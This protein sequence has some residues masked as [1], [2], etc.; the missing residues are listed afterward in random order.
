MNF[1][2][3]KCWSKLSLNLSSRGHSSLT[4]NENGSITVE[5]DEGE[6]TVASFQTFPQRSTGRRRSAS[7]E[8]AGY[9]AGEDGDA[10]TV[11]W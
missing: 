1:R 10:I 4:M 6:E 7:L 2:A 5:G 3:A 11:T 9:A 8:R